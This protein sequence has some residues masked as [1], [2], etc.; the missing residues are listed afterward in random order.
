MIL[1]DVNTVSRHLGSFK[2]S[3]L[4][5]LYCDD[6]SEELFFSKLRDSSGQMKT[7]FI[8]I[9]K[10]GLMFPRPCDRVNNFL[11]KKVGTYEI[12]I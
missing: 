4:E 2:L 1:R 8:Q 11:I 10:S 3:G 6:Q 5:V 7:N 9:C 12:T